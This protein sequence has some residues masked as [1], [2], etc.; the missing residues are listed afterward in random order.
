[1]R[2]LNYFRI[3]E[4]SRYVE[5]NS[6]HYKSIGCRGQIKHASFDW[7]VD[8]VSIA[9]DVGKEIHCWPLLHAAWVRF[10]ISVT[11]V[12]GSIDSTLLW[13]FGQSTTCECSG[14]KAW[15][16]LQLLTAWY[17]RSLSI[18]LK[19]KVEDMRTSCK[20]TRRGTQ[21]NDLK[22]INFRLM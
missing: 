8:V 12:A 18:D 10:T 15:I 14:I 20:D 19:W 21:S 11:S 2:F 22:V 13:P 1:M 5:N 7:S 3:G 4:I 16:L 17:K 9:I 6:I